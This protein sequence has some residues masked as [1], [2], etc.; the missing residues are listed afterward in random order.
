[1][2]YLVY[3]QFCLIVCFG[4]SCTIKTPEVTFTSERTA[5]EKQILGS[6][7]T[8]EEDAWMISSVRSPSQQEVQIPPSK[9]IV[10]EAF[11]NRKFNADDVEDFKRDGLFG[12]NRA[13]LLSL[14]PLPHYGE[15]GDYQALADRVFQ[16]ENQDRE[17]IMSRIVELN[18]AVNPLDHEAVA[19]VFAQMNWDASPPGTWLQLEDERWIK[20]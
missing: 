1:M 18:S 9:R 13:G 6:Y 2:K 16:E 3:V 8:I 14:R 17:T 11:A 4:S 5:L 19:R 12:E 10:L 20:K 7:R 15:D